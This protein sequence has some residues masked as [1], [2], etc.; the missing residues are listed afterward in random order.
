MT[1]RRRKDTGIWKRR[2]GEELALEE[3]MGLW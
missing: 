2:H 1:L 3:P